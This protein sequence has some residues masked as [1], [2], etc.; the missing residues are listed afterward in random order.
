MLGR[1]PLKQRS[2]LMLFLENIKECYNN[3]IKSQNIN[4]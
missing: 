2:E 4:L 1:F 3:A